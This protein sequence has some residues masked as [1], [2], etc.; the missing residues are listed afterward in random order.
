MWFNIIII[1]QVLSALTII[2]LVLLQH[3]KGADMG[4]AFGAGAS[5]SFF[6]ATGS[7][8]FLSRST[9]VAAVVFFIATLIMAYIGHRPAP[10]ASVAD[11][12]ETMTVV[13][14]AKN[15]NAEK[16]AG[17]GIAAVPGMPAESPA[18]KK[19]GK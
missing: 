11:Q 6:G 15:E 17:A 12:M 9:S 14:P 5:G 13:T 3:G 2:G 7:S 4:A 18:E 19:E 16:S 1:V 8:N 10:K